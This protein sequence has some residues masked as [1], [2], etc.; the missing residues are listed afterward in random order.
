MRAHYAV[1]L[2]VVLGI[3]A[4]GSAMQ[5]LRAQASLHCN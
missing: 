3:G 4:G 1:A 2:A 5:V